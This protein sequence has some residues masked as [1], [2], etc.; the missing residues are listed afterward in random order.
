LR[1]ERGGGGCFSGCIPIHGRGERGWAEDDAGGSVEDAADGPA[2][3]WVGEEDFAGALL[4]RAV[5]PAAEEGER[6]A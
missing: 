5:V 2:M 4:L 1:G 3:V 6:V